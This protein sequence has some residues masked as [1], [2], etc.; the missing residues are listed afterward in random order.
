MSELSKRAPRRVNIP[1]AVARMVTKRWDRR[2]DLAT[3]AETIA[4]SLELDGDTVGAAAVRAA[5]AEASEAK[6]FLPPEGP[7][8][9]TWCPSVDRSAELVLDAA[10]GA[11]LERLAG[12][13]A[14]APRFVAAGIDAPTRLFFVGPSGCGK[15]LAAKW[16]A[17]RL[18]LPIA[19]VQLDRVVSSY[20]GDSAKKL[21]DC[22]SA[23]ENA[24][25]S[26]LFLDEIDGICS[27]RQG[28]RQDVQEGSRTT[29][30][31]LQ[32]LDQLPPGQIVIAATNYPDAVD[33][34][35]VR[36]L[37]T[38]L[39]FGLPS[40]QARREMVERWW[41]N[42]ERGAEAVQHVVI[43]TEGCSG[44]TVRSVAMAAARRAIVAGVPVNT[45]HVEAA[46]EGRA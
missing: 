37:P 9:V 22:F 41:A 26:I 17:G 30:S 42:V 43:S 12:E 31:L 16:L 23:V 11:A 19:I 34:A 28:S 38:R 4:R 3:C 39:T 18:G 29:S 2:F 20:L 44:A 13:L 8:V 36:R 25:P 40:E 21:R 33:S 45:R 10:T 6:T 24:G 27:N 35:L 15:T 46:W 5:S 14:A 32:Q 7:A 1:E